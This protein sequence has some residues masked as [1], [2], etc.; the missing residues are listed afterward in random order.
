MST[1]TTINSAT[2]KETNTYDIIT[3]I[4]ATDRLA[5]EKAIDWSVGSFQRTR[6]VHTVALE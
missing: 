5:N 1:I 4:Q 3:E 6:K 2:E